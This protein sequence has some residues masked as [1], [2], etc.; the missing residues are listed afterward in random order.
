M[1]DLWPCEDLDGAPLGGPLAE[2]DAFYDDY[3]EEPTEAGHAEADR[4]EAVE[5][6]LADAGRLA[7]AVGGDLASPGAGRPR[8]CGR[9]LP[10]VGLGRYDVAGVVSV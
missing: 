3:D 6:F 1:S 4:A 9:G 2:H 7:G 5:E 8:R 10:S